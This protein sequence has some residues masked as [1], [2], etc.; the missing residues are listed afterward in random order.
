MDIESEDGIFPSGAFKACNLGLE[1][2][3]RR[4]WFAGLLL[5]LVPRGLFGRG[6][7]CLLLLGWLGRQR[8]LITRKAR[9]FGVRLGVRWLFGPWYVE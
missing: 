2:E 7:R 4:W 9:L 1:L 6:P 3:L 8:P 5:F